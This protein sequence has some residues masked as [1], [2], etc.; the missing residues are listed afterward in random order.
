MTHKIISVDGRGN[1]AFSP[2]W[3]CE[4]AKSEIRA[5][6]GLIFGGIDEDGI[7]LKGTVQIGTTTG[8]LSFVGGQPIPQGN[9]FHQFLPSHLFF[10]FPSIF[11]I[12]VFVF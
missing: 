5:R 12:F 7:A 4:E 8:V 9:N 10:I 11:L 6:F 1:V 3:T 2:D